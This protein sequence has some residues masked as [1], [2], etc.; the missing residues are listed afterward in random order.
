[1]WL[2]KLEAEILKKKKQCLN[3]N[4]QQE[5]AFISLKSNWKV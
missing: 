3:F 4:V 2:F 5:N 1:M